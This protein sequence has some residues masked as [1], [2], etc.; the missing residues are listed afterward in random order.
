[1][2]EGR[3][4]AV[5]ILGPPGVG[6]GT[7]GSLLTE[8][9]G[10]GYIATGDLL[11][12]ASRDRT[13]L[14]K[15]AQGF[16]DSGNLVPDHLMVALVRERLERVAAERGVVFDGFPRTVTQAEALSEA[17]DEVGR[18]VDAVIL[19]EA[20]DQVLVERISGR[21]SCSL[22]GRISNVHF[23]PPVVESTCDECG[24]RLDA[25]GDDAPETV[26]HRLEVYREQ[27]QPLVDHYEDGA[28][29]VLRVDG[30]GSLEQV[31]AT[32]QTSLVAHFGVEA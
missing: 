12:A 13:E 32:I 4:L 9:L 3:G 10:W 26:R 23:D 18:A 28:I 2:V 29:P 8:S 16:M 7:Q 21:R 24:G 19:F 25:R 17:L 11:R 30:E 31:R 15:K 1:M 22:C 5:I 20:S 27:T 14:G 6:K